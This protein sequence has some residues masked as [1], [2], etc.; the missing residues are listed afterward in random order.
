MNH[1]ADYRTHRHKRQ[2]GPGEIFFCPVVKGSNQCTLVRTLGHIEWRI[3]LGTR[4]KRRGNKAGDRVDVGCRMKSLMYKSNSRTGGSTQMADR[5]GSLL[6]CG[7][8]DLFLCP[9]LE[10]ENRSDSLPHKRKNDVFCFPSS[11]CSITQTTHQW[12]M[13]RP[14]RAAGLTARD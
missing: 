5:G 4:V 11:F 14:T 9:V 7:E 12:T 13:L 2:T 10:P 3:S 1:T 8:R 6:P